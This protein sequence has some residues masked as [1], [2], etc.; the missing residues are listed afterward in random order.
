M[1]IQ[2]FTIP[3]GRN[4][5]NNIKFDETIPT[6]EK[7]KT[8][9]SREALHKLDMAAASALFGLAARLFWTGATWVGSSGST[10][11]VFNIGLFKKI[12]ANIE[13]GASGLIKGMAKGFEAQLTAMLGLITPPANT[14]IPPIPFSGYK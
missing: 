6:E 11:L 2:S 3:K 10:H 4:I 1:S 14:G 8:D 9:N 12:E 7:I 13:D 5:L